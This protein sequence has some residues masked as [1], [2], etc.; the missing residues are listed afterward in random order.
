LSVYNDVPVAWSLGNLVFDGYGP[1]TAWSRGA[2]LDV[3]ISH[4]ARC[5]KAAY[6]FV[7]LS[8]EGKPGFHE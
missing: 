5:V 7:Q 2:I 1:D 8:V 4:T 3:K 6:R